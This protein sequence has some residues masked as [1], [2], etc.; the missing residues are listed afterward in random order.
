M[1]DSCHKLCESRL[2]K[3]EELIKREMKRIAKGGGKKTSKKRKHDATKGPKPK[4]TAGK[5]LGTRKPLKKP[6]GAPRV[7]SLGN[8]RMS[9]PDEQ[10]PEFCRRIGARGT[11]E[12]MKLIN[13]FVDENPEV[14]TRQVTIK[15]SEITTRKMPSWM[16]EK[17]KGKAFMKS[18]LL[19]TNC[20]GKRKSARKRRRKRKLKAQRPSP[21]ANLLLL[22]RL[23]M[24]VSKQSQTASL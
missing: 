8:K 4:L 16:S 17:P 3:R 23:R 5:S 6:N 1:D 11:G 22:Q 9:I 19:R 18:M 15:F 14:S 21:K 10:F 24:S 20:F 12:R 2:A 13:A 7:T